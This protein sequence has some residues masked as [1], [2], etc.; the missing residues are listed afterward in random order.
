MC[1]YRGR[2]SVL[3]FSTNNSPK[4]SKSACLVTLIG[5]AKEIIRSQLDN[6]S[7]R[8]RC[9]MDGGRPVEGRKR[10]RKEKEKENGEGEQIYI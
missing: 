8:A 9:Y 2:R 10:R 3:H 6:I 1:A 4:S 5:R 7:R